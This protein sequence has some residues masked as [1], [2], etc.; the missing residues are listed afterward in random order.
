MPV[1]LVTEARSVLAL[2]TSVAV[3][4]VLDESMSAYC[5]PRELS[6]FGSV[7]L[8]ELTDVCRLVK[9]CSLVAASVA[10]P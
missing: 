6:S 1:V 10:L 3:V 2:L 4:R 8:G 7:A 5:I 9:T